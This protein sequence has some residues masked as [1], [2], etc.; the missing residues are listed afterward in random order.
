MT[1]ELGAN[2]LPYCTWT[3]RNCLQVCEGGQ[4]RPLVQ[5]RRGPPAQIGNDARRPAGSLVEGEGAE[6]ER[7]VELALRPTWVCTRFVSMQSRADEWA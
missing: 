1:E 7:G 6:L 3:D 2:L 5:R 4:G